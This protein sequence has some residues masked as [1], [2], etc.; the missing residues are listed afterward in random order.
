MN[1]TSYETKLQELEWDVLP[2]APYSPD[3]APSDYWLFRQLKIFLRGKKFN[4]TG[5]VR[6]AVEEFFNSKTADFYK[7][8]INKLEER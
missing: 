7:R 6:S 3:K 5:E 4:T 1:H 2:H 8:G